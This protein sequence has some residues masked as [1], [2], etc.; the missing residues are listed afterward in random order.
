MWDKLTGSEEEKK[1]E[2]STKEEFSLGLDVESSKTEKKQPDVRSV[3][4]LKEEKKQLQPRRKKTEET[5]VDLDIDVESSK[6]RTS[7]DLDI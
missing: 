6:Q 5:K 4:P 7:I 1:P 3:Q 2:F